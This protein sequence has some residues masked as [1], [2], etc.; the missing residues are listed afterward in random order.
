MRQITHTGVWFSVIP[1]I[2]NGTELGAQKCMDYL[3]M[4]YGINHL[5]LPEHCNIC[6]DA[7]GIYQALYCKKGGLIM[8]HHNE[9]RDRVSD[10]ASKALIPVHVCDDPTIYTGCAMWREGKSRRFPFKLQSR[11]EGGSHHNIPMDAG[12]GQYS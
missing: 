9:L 3:L 8:A 7:F 5:D 6:E 1:S 2:I 10:L 4:R 11:A 12:D